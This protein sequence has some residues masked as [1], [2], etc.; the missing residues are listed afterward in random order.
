MSE[1]DPH[2]RLRA[3]LEQARQR[4]AGA[5]V[6]LVALVHP[7]DRLALEV[8]AQMAATGLA[9]P[10][11]IGARD[12]ILR[13][14]DDSELSIA[15]FEIVPTGPAAPE[16]AQQAT[17]LARQ[18]VVGALM[19]GSLHTDELMSAVVNKESGLRTQRRISHAFVFD[20]PRYHKLLAMADCV[21]NIHP[22]LRTK[23]DILSNAL[24]LLQQI[25]IQRPKVGIVSA[26]ETVNPAIPATVDAQQL[27]QLAHEGAWPGAVIEGPFGFDNVISAEAARIKKIE[28]QVAG[29]ADLLLV[30]DLNAGNMLYKSFNYIGGGD[31]AGLVLGAR[32]PIVLTSRADSVQSR[33]ASVAL[34]VLAKPSH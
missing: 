8:A 23:R 25:G 16:A 10:L 31:C 27:V 5:S 17:H 29:D 22:D 19:K 34:A 18:G 13:A 28:S 32:V 11:L 15:D 7:C 12:L 6:P 4:V 3:L 21:V 9:R 2:P 1:L 14:A 30:P 33:L 24:E 20:L 26:V